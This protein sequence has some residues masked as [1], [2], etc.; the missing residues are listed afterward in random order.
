MNDARSIGSAMQK[1]SFVEIDVAKGLLAILVVVGHA[2]QQYGASLG[3]GWGVVRTVIY[4]FHMASFVFIAGFCS[5]KIMSFK[6]FFDTAEYLRGRA[7]RLLLPY[8]VWGGIYFVLRAM[9]GD[10]ARIPYD[11]S[12]SVF[13]FFG[14]NPDGAMWFLWALFAASMIVVPFARF[15]SCGWSLAV[16][17]VAIA[18][19]I[20]NQ[21]LGPYLTGIN[22]LPVFVF[23]LSFGLFARSWHGRFMSLLEKWYFVGCWLIVFAVACYARHTGWCTQFPW[24]VLSAPAGTIL[25]MSIGR[26]VVRQNRAV[27]DVF[28]FFGRYAMVV[29][30]LGEPTKVILRIAFAKFGVPTQIAFY[31]MIAMTLAVSIVVYRL[32][33]GRSWVLSALLLGAR[34]PPVRK[35]KKALRA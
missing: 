8:V 6:T 22:A 10:C 33:I 15:F 12:H 32:V 2:L 30:V 21:A 24:Y 26:I 5:A 29:Y 13:F 14:Y 3:C 35:K 27:T 31:A 23:F 4:A 7:F 17:W 34:M 11:W 25:T 9:A 1:E 18:V 20:K 16:L 19:Y 28:A